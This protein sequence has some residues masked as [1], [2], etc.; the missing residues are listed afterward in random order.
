MALASNGDLM[1]YKAYS[2]ACATS[3]LIAGLHE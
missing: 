1:L 3:S 2:E